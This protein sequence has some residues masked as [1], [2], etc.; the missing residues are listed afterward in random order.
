MSHLLE[1]AIGGVDATA[2]DAETFAVD[3]LAEQV[4]LGK[5]NLFVKS[6]EFAEFFHVEQHEHARGER[7]VEARE[8]LEAIVAGVKQ[9][10]DPTASA[11]KD[12]RSHA[13]KLLALSQFDGAA[14]N[15]SV[16]QFD[17]GIEK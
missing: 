3:L 7:V 10:V 4:V 11:A 1:A 12:V 15:R 17:I 2:D 16:C 13:M 14:N 6:S 9:L 8:V 5:E